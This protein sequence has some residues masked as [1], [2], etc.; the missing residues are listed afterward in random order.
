[1]KISNWKF[2]KENTRV[3][4]FRRYHQNSA[5]ALR[6][7]HLLL[8]V[9]MIDKDSN[10]ASGVFYAVLAS[11]FFGSFAVPI[12]TRA[13]VKANVDPVAVMHFVVVHLSSLINIISLSSDKL[14][15]S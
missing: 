11:L 2:L 7:K 14:S 8:L 10:F 4:S 15:L 5:R 3:F 13:I 6:D 1:M 12:K 9:H